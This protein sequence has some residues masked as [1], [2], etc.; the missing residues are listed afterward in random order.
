[1]KFGLFPK[2]MQSSRMLPAGNFFLFRYF[3]IGA[4]VVLVLFGIGTTSAYVWAQSYEGRIAPNV[5]MAGFAFG[6]MDPEMARQKLQQTADHFLNRGLDI[7]V[8]GERKNVSLTTVGTTESDTVTD[9][10]DFDISTAVD[11]LMHANRDQNIWPDFFSLAGSLFQKTS[12]PLPISFQKDTFSQAVRDLFPDEEIPAKNAGFLFQKDET[13]WTI[14]LSHSTKGTEFIFD[15]NFF[16]QLQ[17]QFEHLNAQPIEILEQHTFPSIQESDVEPLFFA[18]KSAV[19]QAPYTLLYQENSFSQPKTWIFTPE[20]LAETLEPSHESNGTVILSLSLDHLSSFF[21]PII[22][23]IEKQPTDARF[24]IENGKVV[25]FQKSV[26]GIKVD[27]QAT[28]QQMISMFHTEEKQTSIVV[29]KIEPEMTV[30]NANHLGI[31]E[32]LGVGTSNYKGSPTNRIKNI[33]NGVRLL[34]GIL[35]KPNEEFSLLAALRPIEIENGYYPEMVIKG[36]KIIPEVGGGLCQIGT[37][38]FRAAMLSGLP[39]LERQNHSLLVR[40][41]NDPQNGKPGSDATIYDPA[42]DLRF[43]NDTENTILFQAEMNEETQDIFFTFWGMSDGRK[44]SYTPPEV[45]RSF[46]AGE[47]KMIET[48]TLPPGKEECK[49]AFSGADTSFV[50]TIERPNGTKDEQ[51]FTSHYRSM[52]KMCLV[53]KMPVEESTPENEIDPSI[54]ITNTQVPE[55]S[56]TKTDG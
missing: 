35:I 40:Y 46:P 26:S 51:I 53:G 15:T 36:N 9:M 14:S 8:N 29:I 23:E 17:N 48:D 2:W 38:T 30:D 54:E 11:K 50:Y 44:G 34:N 1:M 22:K 33:R 56:H 37:T 43:F 20:L 52:P 41:Y 55:D 42:P 32:I 47:P 5:E 39:I 16:S 18:A 19:N 12:I 31:K 21:E 28:V 7:V 6:G 3:A 4:G 49:S 13:E 24:T 27:K 25:E 10:V 45:L